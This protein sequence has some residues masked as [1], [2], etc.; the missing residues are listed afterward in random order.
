MKKERCHHIHIR[1]TDAEKKMIAKASK[2]LGLSITNLIIEAVL[3]ST[4]MFPSPS[5]WRR[6]IAEVYCKIAE[7][8]N[9][10]G[11]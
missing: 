2:D 7:D 10:G 3:S 5:L 4:Y 8:K 9:R 11:E 6:R 1:C